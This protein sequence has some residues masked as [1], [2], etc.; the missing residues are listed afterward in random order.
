MIINHDSDPAVAQRRIEESVDPPPQTVSTLAPA[1]ADL[2]VKLSYFR[3]S[4]PTLGP[5]FWPLFDILDD[6]VR[7]N[8]ALRAALE[9]R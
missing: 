7:E 2:A 9:D 6:L 5:T 8:A 4:A 1:G 3:R